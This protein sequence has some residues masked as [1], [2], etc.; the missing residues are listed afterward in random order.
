MFKVTLTTSVRSAYD[1]RH[2]IVLLLVYCFVDVV[3]SQLR[4]LLFGC[5]MSL[6]L[7]WKPRIWFYQLRIE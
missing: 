4:N 3:R 1:H 2:T 6:L 5:V 7:L